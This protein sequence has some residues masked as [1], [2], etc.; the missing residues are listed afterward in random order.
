M[1]RRWLKGTLLVVITLALL[2]AVGV[3][4]LRSWE[5]ALL[6]GKAVRELS[7]IVKSKG[8]RKFTKEN[9]TQVE[10]DQF[11]YWDEELGHLVQRY[12]GD[13][14]WLLYYEVESFEATDDLGSRLMANERQRIA[15]GKRHTAIVPKE[16]YDK[17]DVGQRIYVNYQRFSNLRVTTWDCA[18]TPRDVR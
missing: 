4:A 8:Y 10:G 1:K 9:A 2:S 16:Q 18:T 5:R 12:P 15:A 3:A 13:E 6:D 17:I 7:G 14:D 11:L